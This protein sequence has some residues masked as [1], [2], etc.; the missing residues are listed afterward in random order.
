MAGSL[1][2]LAH[3]HATTFPL[4]P[5][6]AVRR[7]NDREAAEMATGSS[8]AT[9]E[10]R[11]MFDAFQQVSDASSSASSSTQ[12]ALGPVR[13]SMDTLRQ[14]LGLVAPPTR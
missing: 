6:A 1:G 14:A 13:A 9:A 10:A 2:T 8:A 11:Q 4:P 7:I 5:D 3:A 12:S